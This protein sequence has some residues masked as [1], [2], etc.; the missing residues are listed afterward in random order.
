MNAVV[1]K[2]HRWL[3]LTMLAFWFLQAATGVVMAFRWELDDALVA[4]PAAPLDPE[5][6]AATIARIERER[7]GWRTSLVYPSGGLPGRF[8]FRDRFG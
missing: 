7:A 2:F 5:A 8:G 4:G 6:L 3:S 1:K